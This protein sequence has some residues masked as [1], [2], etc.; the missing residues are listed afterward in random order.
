MVFYNWATPNLAIVILSG[1]IEI[2]MMMDQ[3]TIKSYIY[4]GNVNLEVLVVIKV[5]EKELQLPK[6]LTTTQM[7]DMIGELINI[8]VHYRY[9]SEI[10][11]K[12]G[13]GVS[14]I[15]TTRAVIKFLIV[16]GNCGMSS[17]PI[18]EIMMSFNTGATKYCIMK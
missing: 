13:S 12:I 16:L 6:H 17:Q 8:V 11:K 5:T 15:T 4:N 7:Q 9:I 18:E 3:Q 10:S 14:E 1:Q 2:T